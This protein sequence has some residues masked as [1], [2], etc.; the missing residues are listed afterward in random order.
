MTRK[1]TLLAA[2]CALLAA[3]GGDD[4]DPASRTF[5][6]GEP[7]AP[8]LD[9]EASATQGS[10]LIQD[11]VSYRSSD[12]PLVAD[13]TG[14][15][16]FGDTGLSGTAAG[17]S[18][19]K[20]I[21]ASAGLGAATLAP[22]ALGDGFADPAC[23]VITPGRITYDGCYMSQVGMELTWNGWVTR[24][25]DVVAW[26][27]TSVVTMTDVDLTFTTRM[28][29]F[30][31]ITVTPSGMGFRMGFATIADLDLVY[32]ADPFCITG[33]TLE[34]RRV[35]TERMAGMPSTGEYADQGAKFT[36]TGC[37]A[38]SVARSL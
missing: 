12:D 38:V 3:C 18:T 22:E 19:A 13:Q 30:G 15:S 25:G 9:E 7:V 23:V 4:F 5:E 32:A 27:V 37:G 10:T 28:R 31:S 36:W 35:W 8:T 20:A 2:L 26:D 6:Y 17:R 14:G 34:L 11:G 21:A 33:G 24:T 29:L 16:L 1:T